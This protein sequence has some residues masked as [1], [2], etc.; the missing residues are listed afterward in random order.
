MPRP[1][2]ASEGTAARAV[3]LTGRERHLRS[4]M[5]AMAQVAARF[6]RAVKRSLPFLARQRAFL[7][8]EAVC[9]G[10][11]AVS[12]DGTP[13][14]EVL[15]EAEEMPAWGVLSLNAGAVQVLL[16]GALGGGSVS[17]AAS[18]F[19]GELTLAQRAL[20]TRVARSLA[21]DFASAVR[22]EV[23]L[24]LNM[25]SAHTRSEGEDDGP[26]HSDGLR[27]DCTFEG[28]EGDASLSIVVSAEALE[29]AARDN[30]DD[31]PPAADPKMAEAMRDVPVELVAELGVLK[32]GLRQILSLKVGQVLRLQTALEDPVLVRIGGVPK[33]VGV[34]VVSRGQLSIEVR[35]RHED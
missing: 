33:F 26:A 14:F 3:D 18:G 11:P 31:A 6:T 9:I 1:V 4:A 34:P 23:G 10:G 19:N 5:Q 16:Q 15:L 30:D 13:R 28:I 25:V 21:A 17:A 8:A 2:H 7:K 22:D 29:A 20:V 35:G 24:T 32:L 27:V 12:P